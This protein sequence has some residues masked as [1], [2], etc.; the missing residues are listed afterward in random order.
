MT[1]TIVIHHSADFDG[2]FCREIAKKF[3]P[4]ETEFIGWDF[5][6]APLEIPSGR[7]IYVMDLPLD[8][9]FGFEYKPGDVDKNPPQ[10]PDGLVWIDHHKTAILTHPRTIPGYRIDGVAACRLAWQWFYFNRLTLN[11]QDP[12]PALPMKEDFISRVVSEPLAVRLAGEYDIWDKRDPRAETFQYALRSVEPSWEL[13]LG[14]NSEFHTQSMCDMGVNVQNYA[15]RN[16]ESICKHKTFLLDW[17]GLRFLCINTARFN[18]LFFAA[19]D[20][21]ETGHDALLGFS[22]GGKAWTISLYHAN[23]NKEIDLSQIAVKYG[24]G[25]HRGA[26]GFISK[27]LPF[28][29]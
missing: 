28:N 25:G 21:R 24:G 11:E 16:D 12:A 29:L 3:L 18:S 9:V 23:H 27:T 5:T 13:L 10:H 22:W 6:D 20:V 19:R 26:C 8:R 7:A 2:I 14:E 17:E 15:R 1:K 4:P